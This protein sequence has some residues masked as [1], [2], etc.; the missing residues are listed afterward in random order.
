MT[1]QQQRQALADRRG[2][3]ASLY[4]RGMYQA[5]IARRFGVDQKQISRD[6]AYIRKEWMAAAV[7]NF[8]ARKS[9]ELAKVDEV[10]LAA[11]DGW[12]RSQE[13]SKVT[14]ASTTDGN[15]HAKVIE[16]S[17][18]GDARFLTVVLQCVERRC[19]ILGIDAAPKQQLEMSGR[20]AIYLPDNGRL[21]Q[22]GTS[23]PNGAAGGL[24]LKPG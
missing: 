1:R 22:P 9:R 11:W 19:K 4:L 24:S 23:A 21:P 8:D 16:K 3:V 20:V 18:A 12:R 14:E 5:E 10:E 2:Q 15:E 7:G 17:Q 13:T 6:L